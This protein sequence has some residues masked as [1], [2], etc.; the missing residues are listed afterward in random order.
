MGGAVVVSAAGRIASEVGRVAGVGVLDVVEGSALDALEGMIGLVNNQPKGFD[1]VESAVEWH[2]RTGTIN[3]VQSARVSVPPLL[4]Q[5]PHKV[6]KVTSSAPVSAPAPASEGQPEL[7]EDDEP[8]EWLGNAPNTDADSPSRH[9]WIWRADLI[10][11]EP[12]W[13]G[14]FEGLSNRF[15]TCPAARLLLLAGT[16]RLDRELMIGQMQGERGGRWAASV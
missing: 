15:L 3:N 9:D 1:S 7:D 10:R 16:D 2:I 11:S 6:A 5:N 4:V 13:R 12:F 14:W 8:V